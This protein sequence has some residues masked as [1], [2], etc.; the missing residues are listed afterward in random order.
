MTEIGIR[1]CNF[2]DHFVFTHGQD[3]SVSVKVRIQFHYSLT[4]FW[5]GGQLSRRG[6]LYK[7][8]NAR[9]LVHLW[10]EIM[11]SVLDSP[12]GYTAL[13]RSCGPR[14]GISRGSSRTSCIIWP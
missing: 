11:H 9:L 1:L 4:F 6:Q 12:P 14:C 2:L 3:R 13:D 8:N 7:T 10:A 5:G